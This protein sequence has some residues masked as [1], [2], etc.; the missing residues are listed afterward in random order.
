MKSEQTIKAKLLSLEEDLQDLHD[1]R[2]ESKYKF[3]GISEEDNLI[4]MEDIQ[5]LTHE[6]ESLKWV[7]S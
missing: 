4:F 6:I 2:D 1:K 7:L 5:K 3:G